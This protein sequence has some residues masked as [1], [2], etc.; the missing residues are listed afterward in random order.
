MLFVKPKHA[1]IFVYDEHEVTV[2]QNESYCRFHLVLYKGIHL[3][4][5]I[6]SKQLPIYL[7]VGNINIKTSFSKGLISKL[8]YLFNLNEFCLYNKQQLF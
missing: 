5:T 6:L 1:H 3:H 7:G 8:N 4:S 2:V